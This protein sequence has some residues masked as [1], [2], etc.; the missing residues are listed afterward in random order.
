[1]AEVQRRRSAIGQRNWETLQ[2]LYYQT[3]E[4]ERE[5]ARIVKDKEKA[6]EGLARNGRLEVRKIIAMQIMIGDR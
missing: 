4:K 6:R 2:D 3:L 5:I 1:M